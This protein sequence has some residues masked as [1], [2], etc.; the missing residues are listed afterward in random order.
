MPPG[1]SWRMNF[2]NRSANPSG[3][4]SKLKPTWSM[5]SEV[6]SGWGIWPG[7]PSG[8][9]NDCFAPPAA[10]SN[11]AAAG[12]ESAPPESGETGK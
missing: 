7:S 4:E 11:N 5:P 12:A 9:H 2:F 10:T 1:L 3:C 8:S 6:F